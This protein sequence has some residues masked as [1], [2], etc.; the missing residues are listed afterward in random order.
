VPAAGDTG[1]GQVEAAGSIAADSQTPQVLAFLDSYFTAINKHSYRDYRAL[2][3]PAEAEALTYPE[4][5]N[6]YATTRDSAET[7]RGISAAGNGDTVARVTFTSHQ[8][9]A[10]SVGGSGQTCT[11][12]DVLLY[13]QPDGDGYLLGQSPPGYRASYAAC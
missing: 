6:G 12:W 4:F 9:A 2:L 3:S 11:G 8:A 1:N 7:L 5:Q 10:N 13:L